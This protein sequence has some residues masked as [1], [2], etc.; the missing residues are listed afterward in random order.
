MPW[1]SAVFWLAVAWLVT[2]AAT[3]LSEQE[4]TTWQ[5]DGG[6]QGG[7]EAAAAS[8]RP[9]L[10]HGHPP[11]PRSAAGVCAAGLEAAARHGRRWVESKT[12]LIT[13]SVV[14]SVVAGVRRWYIET[15]KVHEERR[16]WR[17]PT[18]P[19]LAP[20]WEQRVAMDEWLA[21]NARRPVSP[22]PTEPRGTGEEV[23]LSS[24]S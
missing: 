21:E 6:G 3:W 14:L 18:D 15:R 4:E 12:A 1:S 24:C 7:D 2:S 11:V 19:R 13:V 5:S 8:G 23:K 10:P 9:A 16:K 22:R 20:G 17:K